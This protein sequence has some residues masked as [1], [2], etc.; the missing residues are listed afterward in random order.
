MP[1][2]V[3]LPIPDSWYVIAFS[4]EL[5]AGAALARTVAEREI[6]LFRTRGGTACALDAYCPH[7][8]AHLGIGGR[9][10]DETLRCP[11]HAF[12]FDTDGVCVATGYGT[13]PPPTARARVWPLREVN[14][15][16]FVYY[17]SQ[18]DSQRA[19]LPKPAWE[20]PALDLAGW[21]PLRHRTF[22][23]RDHP[24]ETVEN[25]VDLGHFAIVHG[26][27][28]LALC[29]QMRSEGPRF[30]I[31][32]AGLRRAPYVGWLGAR[33]RF[34]FDIEIFGMGYSLV[35]VSVERLG[36]AGRLFVL[37][38]PTTRER[39]DL[40]LAF[41]LR[42]IEHPERIHPLA[43]LAPRGLLE[44]LIA[45]TI[46]AGAVHDAQ[47]DFPIW[48]H[49]RHIQPPALA[50]GDGPI[51]AFR[52]WARQFYPELASAQATRDGAAG[53]AEVAAEV[54]ARA[55]DI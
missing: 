14:G 32:Y 43:R 12:R 34:R 42:H 41:S 24:Q 8:G 17:D 46:F 20:P 53:A 2:V 29:A 38:T 4:E 35:T 40:S 5:R 26:Y 37:A 28:D 11:F 18:C 52:I 16:I 45:R 19:T 39:I 13:K 54:A 21:G 33:S 30:S 6:V 22:D 9:V 27:E 47:Q 48:E 44:R 23:L 3:A 15:L 7:L 55:L 49:K 31:A 36:L 10:V 50:Q 1:S 51:G 25:S